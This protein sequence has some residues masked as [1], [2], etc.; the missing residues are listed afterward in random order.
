MTTPT[1]FRAFAEN[2]SDSIFPIGVKEVKRLEVFLS[3]QKI[4]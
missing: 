2:I 4:D 1:G 3:F